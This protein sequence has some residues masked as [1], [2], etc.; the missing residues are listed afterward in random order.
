MFRYT[1]RG[2]PAVLI[3]KTWDQTQY[4]PNLAQITLE[5]KIVVIQILEDSV[6]LSED[7]VY[8]VAKDYVGSP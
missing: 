8:S 4:L 7:D 5:H 3:V 2:M 6:V 1:G